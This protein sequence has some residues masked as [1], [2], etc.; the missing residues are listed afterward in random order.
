MN[1]KNKDSL[2]IELLYAGSGDIVFRDKIGDGYD[3]KEGEGEDAKTY[4]PTTQTFFTNINCD[5]KFKPNDNKKSAVPGKKP[6]AGNSTPVVIVERDY[7]NDEAAHLHLKIAPEVLAVYGDVYYFNQKV[8]N[9]TEDGFVKFRIEAGIIGKELNANSY[10]VLYFFQEHG[11]EE[12]YTFPGPDCLREVITSLLGT[13]DRGCFSIESTHL[14]SKKLIMER[15][16]GFFDQNSEANVNVNLQG[17]SR[18][19]VVASLFSDD[20]KKFKETHP[21]LHVYYLG[22]DPVPGPYNSSTSRSKD[23]DDKIKNMKGEVFADKSVVIYSLA[24][25]YR[26]S[27]LVKVSADSAISTSFKPQK[28]YMANIVIIDSGN[29]AV[30]TYKGKK[31][32]CIY[33][34]NGKQTDVRT[35]KD[36][37]YFEFGNKLER[38][39]DDYTKAME[40]IK[41]VYGKSEPHRSKYLINLIYNK[42]GINIDQIFSNKLCKEY[43]NE[44]ENYLKQDKLKEAKE[45][46]V[47]KLEEFKP[48]FPFGKISRIL[49]S[50]ISCVKDNNEATYTLLIGKFQTLKR[51]RTDVKNDF[52]DMIKYLMMQLQIKLRDHEKF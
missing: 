46:M 51:S 48:K 35:L 10:P 44:F 37:I 43:L 21:G 34:Y 33:D 39:N 18:G 40:A 5:S 7:I 3:I 31:E 12:I 19:G 4:A 50:V 1:S 11:N 38:L 42:C 17:H 16:T 49:T 25:G 27:Y 2:N 9:K 26:D 52:V 32:N 41:I 29:H 24:S 28:L 47:K 14:S 20:L 6:K 45:Y 8:T 22:H 13:L 36:G 30:Q 23:E 15:L